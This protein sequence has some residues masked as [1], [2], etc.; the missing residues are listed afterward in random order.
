MYF[1]FFLNLFAF[2]VSVAPFLNMGSISPYQLDVFG[3]QIYFTTKRTGADNFVMVVGKNATSD[4]PK[5]LFT[6]QANTL[7]GIKVYHE[8]RYQLDSKYFLLLLL[9]FFFQQF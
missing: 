3:A 9:V 6:K 2:C 5:I 7:G 4:P 8:R 1:F